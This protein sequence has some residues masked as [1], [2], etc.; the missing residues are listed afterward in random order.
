VYF[1]VVKIPLL[2]FKSNLGKHNIMF[3]Y[4]VVVVASVATIALLVPN[5]QLKDII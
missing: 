3:F 5:S 4:E 2:S 1:V